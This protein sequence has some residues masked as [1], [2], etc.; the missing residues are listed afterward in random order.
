M[1]VNREN[2]VAVNE[3]INTNLSLPIPNIK[4]DLAKDFIFAVLSI[5]FL[6]YLKESSLGFAQISTLFAR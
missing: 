2:Y 6:V 1:A 5:V 3:V 4:K